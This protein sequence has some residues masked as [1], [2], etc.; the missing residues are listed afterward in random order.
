MAR[1]VEEEILYVVWSGADFLL[2]VVESDFKLFS[3]RHNPDLSC[4]RV[5]RVTRR[6]LS[7]ELMGLGRALRT[8]FTSFNHSGYYRSVDKFDPE[9]KSP[10]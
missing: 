10:L 3:L 7:S 4:A 2:G 8:L 6:E 5:V 9:F 1:A